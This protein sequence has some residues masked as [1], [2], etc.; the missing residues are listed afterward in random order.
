MLET[1]LETGLE[2]G[3]ETGKVARFMDEGVNRM[4]GKVNG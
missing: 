4:A 1:G 3:L 2:A